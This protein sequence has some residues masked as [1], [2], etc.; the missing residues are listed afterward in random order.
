MEFRQRHQL[1][2]PGVS[3]IEVLMVIAV[4]GTISAWGLSGYAASRQHA[5]VTKESARLESAV[6][7][8]QSR[9]MTAQSG[10][11]WG[12]SCRGQ[13]FDIFAYDG[14]TESISQAFSS[15]VTCPAG[16][17]VKFA[18]LTGQPITA[19]DL[20]LSVQGHDVVRLSIGPAGA[21][22]IQNL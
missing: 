15:G 4:I 13:S 2:R 22:T 18:K 6:R 14:G 11:P 12:V 8:A 3:L 20:R 19:A 1:N 21:I 9:S 7:E 17:M 5:E 10:H 16:D